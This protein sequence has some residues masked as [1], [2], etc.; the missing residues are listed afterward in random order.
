ME[1]G[2]MRDHDDGP[3]IVIERESGGFGSFILGAMVGAAVALLLAPQ[4]GEETQREI[5]DRARRLKDAAEDRVRDAQRQIESR[6]EEARQGVGESVDAVR[7]AVDSGRQAAVDARV[8]LERRL[9]RSKAA[10]RAGI[11]AARQASRET[12]GSGEEP[13][14]SEA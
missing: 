3:Y 4:S 11:D 13:A 10:Y 9:E 6:L 14:G 5:R 8:E 12:E 2:S 1:E 7:E